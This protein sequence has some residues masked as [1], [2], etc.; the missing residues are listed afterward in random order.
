MC[1]R[2]SP[3]SKSPSTPGV[4]VRRQSRYERAS[5]GRPTRFARF[6]RMQWTEPPPIELRPLSE[7]GVIGPLWRPITYAR[8]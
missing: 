7:D 8:H 5:C 3:G 4:V 1:L 2:Q 6:R